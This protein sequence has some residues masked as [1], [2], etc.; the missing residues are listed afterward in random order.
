MKQSILFYLLI[1]ITFFEESMHCNLLILSVLHYSKCFEIEL[2]SKGSEPRETETLN[3]LDII[4]NAFKAYD[5][6]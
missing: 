1:I 2:H 4:R 3:F 6:S 5:L